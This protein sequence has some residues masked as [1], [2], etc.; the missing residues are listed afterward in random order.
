MDYGKYKYQ[1][2]KK[3][4]EAKKKQTVIHVKEVKMGIKTNEHDLKYK[5]S[6]IRT[7]LEDKN[8][9]K[10]SIVFRGREM[11]HKE[12]GENILNRI[13]KELEDIGVVEQ[14]PKLEGKS[15]SIMISPK[16]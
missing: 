13:A 15:M 14:R 6:H 9:A 1:Q 4:Q 16:I 5:L 11:L 8:K 3:A 7:F 2:D 12:S 10:I